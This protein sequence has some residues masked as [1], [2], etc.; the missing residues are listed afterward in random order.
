VR[1]D[2][3]FATAPF[4]ELS[5]TEQALVRESAVQVHL[6][7][8][9][10]LLTPEATPQHLWLLTAGHVEQEEDGRSLVLGAGAVLGWRA[11]LTERCHATATA[12]D[13]VQAWKLPRATVL[14][15]LAANA[16]FSARVFADMSHDKTNGVPDG[17][18]VDQAGRVFCTGTTGSGAAPAA[19]S[20]TGRGAITSG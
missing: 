8:G 9:D 7:A 13:A 16:R 12:L 1:D 11:L 2:S 17:M 15:L 4:D 10:S 19:A 3:C 14:A 6:G 20:Y 18:K 5:A